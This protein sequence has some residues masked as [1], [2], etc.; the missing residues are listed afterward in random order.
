MFT[1]VVSY[2]FVEF[3]TGVNLAVVSLPAVRDGEEEQR[4]A[5]GPGGTNY[6]VVGLTV[7]LW[8]EEDGQRQNS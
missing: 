4:A 3:R 5:R 6:E 2:S 7:P 8:S 1:S